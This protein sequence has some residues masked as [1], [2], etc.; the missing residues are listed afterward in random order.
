M[1]RITEHIAFLNDRTIPN[2]H[3]R[4][5]LYSR[6]DINEKL[7]KLRYQFRKQNNCYV[8]RINQTSTLHF[9]RLLVP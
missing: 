3:S 2:E 4:M 8:N 7:M 6:I 1:G 9:Y 5:F